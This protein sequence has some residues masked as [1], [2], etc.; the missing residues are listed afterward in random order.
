MTQGTARNPASAEQDPADIETMRTT[1]R[2][3][4]D[5]DEPAD[6]APLLLAQLRG[7]I[8]LMI[9]EVDGAAARQSEDDIPRYCALACVGEARMKLSLAAGSGLSGDAAYARRLARVL[10]ALCD[11]YENLGGEHR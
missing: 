8:E 4:L 1:A 11:H 2:R 5:P 10:N 7:Q 3:A 6:E 9:P